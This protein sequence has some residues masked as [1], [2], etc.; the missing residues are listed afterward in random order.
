MRHG[1]PSFVFPPMHMGNSYSSFS[2]MDGTAV[3]VLHCSHPSRPSTQQL[4]AL[5][6]SGRALKALPLWKAALRGS[7]LLLHSKCM[8]LME[9]G[10]DGCVP[11]A[12]QGKSHSFEEI[13]NPGMLMLLICSG[14]ASS[15]LL[16]VQTWVGVSGALSCRFQWPR[17]RASPIDPNWK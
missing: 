10:G 17:V 16:G 7:W 3:D 5:N 15:R 9:D 12:H 8:G 4:G 1:L 14:S 13:D 11:R 6:G 2:P